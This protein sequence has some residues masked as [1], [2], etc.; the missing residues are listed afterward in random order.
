MSIFQLIVFFL[1][2]SSNKSNV[3][4]L[5]IVTFDP[6]ANSTFEQ[7]LLDPSYG[8]SSV[9]VSETAEIAMAQEETVFDNNY[10]DQLSK[11]SV[12][13][14]EEFH[15]GPHYE[16]NWTF[17]DKE[18][19]R[20]TFFLFSL[21][22]I[23]TD[24]PLPPSKKQPLY[25]TMISVPSSST[26]ESLISLKY[27]LF[28]IRQYKTNMEK[29][30]SMDQLNLRTSS[31]GI[32]HYYSNALILERL[33]PK[34][35]YSICIYYY[36]VNSSSNIADLSI[37]VDLMHDHSKHSAHGLLFVLTQYSIILGI[38]IVLQG[39]FSMRK[40]RLAHIIHQHFLNRK[41]RI[42]STLSSVSLVRQS[43]SSASVLPEDH[44]IE[45]K[46]RVISSPAIIITAPSTPSSPGS[47]RPID[48]TEPLI[49]M[50]SNRNHVHFFCHVDEDSDED[51]IVFV[52]PHHEPYSDQPNA[53]LCMTHI[54]DTNKPWCKH[55]PETT[56][57]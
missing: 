3:I 6:E 2:I 49:E 22:K 23:S 44:Q 56:P 4:P 12:N 40:R 24:K 47:P 10:S 37:C 5:T 17:V 50:T 9:I 16:A 51:D 45:L 46:K 25:T 28:V 39:L 55:S 35:K 41:Q 34:E 20:V 15:A 52:P 14:T 8:N 7:G 54:L 42:L 33:N 27:Y 26:V 18:T 48:E 11:P 13:T 19:V 31:T 36:Q 38:L 30:L 32:E 53:L 1:S 43:F 21:L 57:V 29:I